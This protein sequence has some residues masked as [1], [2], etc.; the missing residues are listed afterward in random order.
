MPALWLS[1]SGKAVQRP[2]GWRGWKT[3][4]DAKRPEGYSELALTRKDGKSRMDTIANQAVHW[5]VAHSPQ[6]Q[7]IMQHGPSS[8][9]SD[10]TSRR[11]LNPLFVEW[12]MNWPIGWTNHHPLDAQIV[13]EWEAMA[14]CRYRLLL[15]LPCC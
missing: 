5:P 14:L 4:S 9:P 12:L 10:Q 11:R 15:P 7:Q 13:S 6:A 8:S 2:T 3:S 1:L